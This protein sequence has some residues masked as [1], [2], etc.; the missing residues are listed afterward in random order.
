[1]TWGAWPDPSKPAPNAHEPISGDRIPF[2]LVEDFIRD[3]ARRFVVRTVAFDPWRFDR[4][5]EILMNEGIEMLEFPQ[6]N[7]RMAPASQGLFDAVVETR[8]AFPDDKVIAGQ[9]EAATAKQVG[10]DAWRLDKTQAAEA[11]DYAVALSIALKVAEDEDKTGSGFSI[12]FMDAVEGASSEDR[13]EVDDVV[14]EAALY[15]ATPVPW[16]TL[17]AERAHVVYTALGDL[18]RVFTER[19]EAALADVCRAERGRKRALDRDAA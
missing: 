10:R 2:D 17:D 11:M 5:A 13:L 7:E 1:M 19:G 12:R 8:L 6:S 15:R 4:S 18:A 9:M 14:V 3:C 16:E